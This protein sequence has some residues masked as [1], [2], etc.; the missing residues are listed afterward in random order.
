MKLPL[1]VTFRHMDTSDAVLAAIQE[2]AAKLDRFSEHIMACRVVVE[3]PHQ[4]HH[5]GNLFKVGVDITV[6]GGEIFA[7]R[8]TDKNHAHEDVYVAIRDAFAAAKRQL[9]DYAREIRQDVKT[10]TPPPHGTVLHLF[11]EQDYGIIASADGREIYFHRNSVL[12]SEFDSLSPGTEVR[13][14]EERGV[15]GPQA[16]T[17]AMLGKHHI[18]ETQKAE[19]SAKITERSTK[20]DE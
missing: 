7:S 11:P 9:E 19:H 5:K 16:S 12:N 18:V 15:E 3:A 2:K 8:G 17:V 20:C 4:H 1:Q 14:D 6:P 13:F 10:H